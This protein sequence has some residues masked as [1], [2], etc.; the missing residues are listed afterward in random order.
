VN[1]RFKV[2]ALIAVTFAVLGVA[3]IL[4]ERQVVMSSFA[5]LERADARSTMRRVDNA[6]DLTLERVALSATDWGN[7]A[8]TYRFVQDHNPDYVATNIT[9]LAL[10]QLNVNALLVVDPDGRFVLS[11]D[12]DLNSDRPLGLDF[13][14]RKVLPDDFP[15]RAALRDGRPAKGLLQTNHGILMLAGAPVLDGNGQGPARG[16]VIL[17]RLLSSAAIRGIGAQTQAQLAMLAP[18]DHASAELTE[19]ATLTQVYRSFNDLYG[20]PLMRLRVDVP[21]EVTMRGRRALLYASLCLIAA[22]VIVLILLVVVLSRM[23]LSPLAVVTRHAVA[24]GEDKDLTT[25]LDLKRDDEIGVLA[26]EFDRMVARVAESRT[27][28]VDQSFQ[29]GFAELATGVLH[30]LGNAMTPI[31]VRLASLTE[32]LRAAPAADAEQAAAELRGGMA[33]AQRRADLQEFLRLACKELALTT[34]VAQDDVAVITRQT[35]LI[36]T[37]LSEQMRS[38]RNQHVIEPVRL[39]ELVAQSLE[40]VPDGCRAR[41]VIDA[42]DTLRGL[43]V[44]RV[45]R[46]VLRLILQNLIINAADAVRDAGK[47][48]GVLHVSAEIVHEREQQQLH[49]HCKDDGVGIPAQNLARVFENGFSTKSPETNHGIGLHWCAN[50]I[51]AL[52]GRIWA[53][54]DGP[55]RGASIHLIVPLANRETASLAGAA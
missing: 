13:A 11:R 46:T 49:L 12:L 6:L 15:W 33:D 28:L 29:A 52:G 32:R 30:N 36:Q 35:H 44:V 51:G 4:V 24:L 16:M 37:A 45:A 9:D 42:D 17:G 8:D 39:T 1:I 47:E 21:R 50:A 34:R 23:I 40:I 38:A 25:R 14:A 53:T 41:L 22:A 5:E 3:E 54:S 7:W 18:V 2:I 20:R 48:R 26:R 10:R 19:S 31:G 55:G 43:G 27:Q